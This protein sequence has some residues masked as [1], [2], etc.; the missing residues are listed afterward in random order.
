MALIETR[1]AHRHL[2]LRPVLFSAKTR[3]AIWRTRRALAKL[4]SNQLKDIGISAAQ[5]RREARLAVWD[6][7][8]NW[9]CR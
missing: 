5:A 9:A 7:P 3:L 2:S 1:A 4:D 6:V 8:S